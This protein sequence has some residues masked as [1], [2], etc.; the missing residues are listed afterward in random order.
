MKKQRLFEYR[1]F[2]A[3]FDTEQSKDDVI[4]VIV[5]HFGFDFHWI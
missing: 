4:A 2:S 1:L 5:T 3:I